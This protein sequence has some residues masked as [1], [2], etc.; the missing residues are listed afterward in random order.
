MN[1]GVLAGGDPS[2]EDLD[3]VAQLDTNDRNRLSLVRGR[4]EK[5]IGGITALAG[6]LSTV[7]IVKGPS[8]TSDFT[9]ARRRIVG[10]LIGFALVGFSLGIYRAYQ[11]AYGD[12]NYLDEIATQPVTGLATRLDQA[13]RAAASAA[14]RQL[15]T[16]VTLTLAALGLLAVA[17]AVTWFSPARAPQVGTACLSVDGRRVAELAGSTVTIRALQQGA[18]IGPCQDR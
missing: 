8:L 3:A 13:R 18:S 9:T 7:L 2:R 14:Q 11:S 6:L 12:P 17:T 1:G 4:A 10:L 15:G 16:A 5:W